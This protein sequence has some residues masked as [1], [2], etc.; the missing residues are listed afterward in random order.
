M[1]V[2][3]ATGAEV[4]VVAAAGDAVPLSGERAGGDP[5]ALLVPDAA[6]PN[7]PNAAAVPTISRVDRRF[8]VN[9]PLSRGTSTK[10]LDSPTGE[11]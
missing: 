1:D 10:V 3:P 7:V 11:H 8:T 4:G 2:V 6:S 9:L 5:P